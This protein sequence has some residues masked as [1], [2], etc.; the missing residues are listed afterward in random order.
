MKRILVIG[1]TSGIATSCMRIWAKGGAMF[2]LVA[3][4]ADRLAQAAADLEIRGARS[5]H[6]LVMDALDFDAYP[7][8]LEASIA[9]LRHIDI[10]FIAHGT[11][12]DQRNCER[13]D[14]GLRTAFACNAVSTI[15]LLSLLAAYFECQRRGTIAVIT[16]VAAERGRP[17]NYVYGSAK[18]AVSTFCEGLRA[19]L[20]RSGVHLSEIRPGFVATPMT[21]GLAVPYAIP[22]ADPVAVAKR[23]VD[24]I[25]RRAD[26]LYAPAFWALI[27]W[28]IRTIPR[29]L[30]KRLPL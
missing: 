10:A 9:S 3:R 4:S 6:T 26:V 25:E 8:M 28:V 21:R 29:V 14:Q 12:P 30:F 20:H 15:S 27:M 24:G 7:G 16:S 13:D 1:A 2:F 23:I 5:V 17:S 19:R 18:A 11:L 22:M